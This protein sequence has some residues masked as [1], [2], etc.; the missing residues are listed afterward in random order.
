MYPVSK[1]DYKGVLDTTFKVGGGEG[2][3]CDN[4]A[5]MKHAKNA[6]PVLYPEA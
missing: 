6:C 2:G 5:C 3:L 4:C 1:Y